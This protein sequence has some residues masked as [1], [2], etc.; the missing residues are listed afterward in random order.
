MQGNGE[1]FEEGA[2]GG[3]VSYYFF[4][5]ISLFSYFYFIIKY[6]VSKKSKSENE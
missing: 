1:N 2:G 6:F 5:L 4:P 3:G